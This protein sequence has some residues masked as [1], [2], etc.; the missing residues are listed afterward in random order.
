MELVMKMDNE[1][2]RYQKAQKRVK[3][4]KGFYRHLLVFSIVMIVIIYI[5]LKYTPEVLWFIW[6]LIGSAI[7]LIFHGMK[8]FHLFPFF[9][10]NWEE[11]KMKQFM[12][13]DKSNDNKFE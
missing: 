9:D 5:N 12:E 6:T 11:K 4:I 3:E 8:V 2:E 13:E 10:T 1:L 7:P